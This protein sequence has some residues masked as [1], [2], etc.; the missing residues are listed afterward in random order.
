MFGLKKG[1][2][3]LFGSEIGSGFEGLDGAHSFL[4]VLIGHSRNYGR[5]GHVYPI[6]PR[7]QCANKYF[8]FSIINSNLP[9]TIVFAQ[10]VC[11]PIVRMTA[12][13]SPANNCELFVLLKLVFVALPSGTVWVDLPSPSVVSWVANWSRITF[14]S[15]MT[16]PAH[17]KPISSV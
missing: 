10:Y 15:L 12:R 4:N 2:E 13:S 1:I 9:N 3:G 17:K 7:R 5:T 14:Y 11:K 16:H 6:D 8:E